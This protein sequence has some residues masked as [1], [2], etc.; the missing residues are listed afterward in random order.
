MLFFFNLPECS[1]SSN[2][3]LYPLSHYVLMNDDFIKNGIVI[4]FVKV[5]ISN[6][7]YCRDIIIKVFGQKHFCDSILFCQTSIYEALLRI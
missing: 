2:T 7:H 4:I 5:P 6:L 1:I 3:C